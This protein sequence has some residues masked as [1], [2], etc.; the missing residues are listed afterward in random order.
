MLHGGNKKYMYTG[1]LKN[2]SYWARRKL[3][4]LPCKGLNNCKQEEIVN[5]TKKCHDLKNN[6]VSSFNS[7]SQRMTSLVDAYL[8]DANL[9]IRYK[10]KKDKSL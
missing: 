5:V 6:E 3:S 2:K 10:Y 8:T 9:N 4:S 1:S 7:K